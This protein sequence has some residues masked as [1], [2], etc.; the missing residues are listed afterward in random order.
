MS[1]RSP[2][3]IYVKDGLGRQIEISEEEFYIKLDE[4]FSN[5]LYSDSVKVVLTNNLVHEAMLH[6]WFTKEKEKYNISV[7]F[8]ENYILSVLSFTDQER[9]E[10]Y[11][12]SHWRRAVERGLGLCAQHAIVCSEILKEYGIESSTIALDGHIVATAEIRKGKWII[13]DPTSG[14]TIPYSLNEVE[15][16]VDIIRPYYSQKRY[17]KSI[18]DK[19]AIIYNRKGNFI[20]KNK[21]PYPHYNTEFEK[22][23][24]LWKWLLPILFAIPFVLKK[25]IYLIK[26]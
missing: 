2:D 4:I 12:F 3:L 19:L 1:L 8:H 26:L 6:F 15:D 10:R 5:Y 17:P 11:E 23:A 20:M 21:F 14:V 18:I 16:N 25:M 24:Y 22:F 9:F 7:P 13:I